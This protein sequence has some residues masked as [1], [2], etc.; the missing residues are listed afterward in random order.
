MYYFKNNFKSYR[1]VELPPTQV[2]S[3]QQHLNTHYNNLYRE[4]TISPLQTATPKVIPTDHEIEPN[5]IS[6]YDSNEDNV[7]ELVDRNITSSVYNSPYL[8]IVQFYAHWCG[9]CQRFAPVWKEASNMFRSK[10]IFR[11]IFV[12]E[13]N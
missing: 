4:V 3:S 5:Y 10:I 6:L 7:V 8:W 12:T 13:Y 2:S 11:I 1:V 9:H